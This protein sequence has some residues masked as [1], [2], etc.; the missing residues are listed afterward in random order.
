MKL[1]HLSLRGDSLLSTVSRDLADAS[2]SVWCTPRRDVVEIRSAEPRSL[3]A[4][5]K[6]IRS[7][8]GRSLEVLAQ[9]PGLLRISFDCTTDPTKHPDA[10]MAKY[11]A[12]SL[13]PKT[14]QNGWKLHRVVSLDERRLPSLF[15]AL[16][17][18]S[19]VRVD[20]VRRISVAAL[21]DLLVLSPQQ[22]LAGLTTKQE[23]ALLLAIRQG[24]YEYPRRISI[25]ETAKR[26]GLGRASFNEQLRRA[27][28]KVITALAP[29]LSL[30]VPD[31]HMLGK[32]K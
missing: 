21:G 24:L 13:H 28:A 12:V 31:Q 30:R 11:G 26:N 6:R 16:S 9:E 20:L 27:E 23:R 2:F 22:L 7:K 17:A 4:A 15:R 29:L 8:A 3:E 25:T 5:R 19:E 14:Y 32:P 18:I 1:L 10:I